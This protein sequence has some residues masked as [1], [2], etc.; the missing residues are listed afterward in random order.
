[1]KEQRTMKKLGKRRKASK[2]KKVVPITQNEKE[3]LEYRLKKGTTT[4]EEAIKFLKDRFPN[5]TVEST[6]HVIDRV[7]HSTRVKEPKGNPVC[8]IDLPGEFKHTGSHRPYEGKSLNRFNQLWVM[9]PGSVVGYRYS[10]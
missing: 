7:Y 9:P 4:I 6:E 3:W 2:A 10:G 5:H 8:I 1:M